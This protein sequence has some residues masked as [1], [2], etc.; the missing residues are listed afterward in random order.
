LDWSVAKKVSQKA[1]KPL[2]N[3]TVSETLNPN[4]TTTPEPKADPMAEYYQLKKTLL[5]AT[6]GVTGVVFLV[7]WW[8]YSL[9]IALNYLIGSCV[10]VIYLRRLAKD[11]E[12]IGGEQPNFVG[13]TRLVLFIGLIIFATQWQ[14]LKVVP[15]FLGFIT[16]KAA[17]VIY[18]LQGLMSPSKFD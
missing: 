10:G 11:V 6:L 2:V 13:N 18:M 8:I 9:N 14:Q 15:I 7:V 4:E 1:Q 16:Y 17:I 12:R 5:V 3:K